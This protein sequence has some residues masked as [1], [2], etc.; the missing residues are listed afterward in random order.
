M[1]YL[2]LN[3]TNVSFYTADHLTSMTPL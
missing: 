1:T 2:L 3:P